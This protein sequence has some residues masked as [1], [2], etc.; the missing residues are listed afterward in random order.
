MNL[1]EYIQSLVN[2]GMSKEDMIP[3][4]EAFKNKQSSESGG[5]NDS[6]Q[7]GVTVDQEINAAP[8]VVQPD[9]AS[10]LE[11]TF[12]GLQKPGQEV[13]TE[14]D[15][16]G[17]VDPIVEKNKQ[18]IKDFS[19]RVEVDNP[20]LTKKINGYRNGFSQRAKEIAE[21][22]RRK[23]KDTGFEFTGTPENGVVVIGESGEEI[24]V[25]D[26][27]NGSFDLSKINDFISKNQDTNKRLQS[28][29]SNQKVKNYILD[30][31]K[32]P[33]EEGE[34]AFETSG[35]FGGKRGFGIFSPN[36]FDK[37]GTDGTLTD[38]ENKLPNGLEDVRKLL[39]NRYNETLFFSG[40][41]NESGSLN[42]FTLLT[43]GDATER[44]G[45]TDYKF[46]QMFN[47]AVDQIKG[48]EAQT[49]YNSRVDEL[50][51]ELKDNYNLSD[52]D[53]IDLT[54]PQT[55]RDYRD[56][57]EYTAF[58]K[59]IF[60]KTVNGLRYDQKDI[61]KLKA[62]II[63]K[64]NQVS[65]LL[66]L[67]E[68][69]E[70]ESKIKSLQSEIKSL[71]AK[72]VDL[73]E[74][75][76][77]E[78]T[79]LYLD[80][81]QGGVRFSPVETKGSVN[82]TQIKKKYDDEFRD[83]KLSGDFQD[84]QERF[85]FWGLEQIDL[86]EELDRK[87]S[88][89]AN[90]K[91]DF[92]EWFNM[93]RRSQ[94]SRVSELENI[95]Y[96]KETGELSGLTYRDLVSFGSVPGIDELSI[97]RDPDLK[98]EIITDLKGYLPRLKERL[99]DIKV[100]GQAL[101]DWYVMNIDPADMRRQG[102]GK[103]PR[104]KKGVPNVGL[105]TFLGSVGEG[106]VETITEDPNTIYTK[107]DEL[108]AIQ[109]VS[110]SIPGFQWNK[111]QQNN[112]KETNAEF[113]G[114]TLGAIA[115]IAVEFAALNIVSGGVATATGLSESLMAMRLGRVF[116]SGKQVNIGLAQRAATQAGYSKNAKAFKEFLGSKANRYRNGKKIY[117]LEGATV[118]EKGQALFVTGLIEEGKMQF[119]GLPTGSGFAFGTF[120]GLANSVTTRLG[121]SFSEASGFSALNG[122]LKLTRGGVTFGMA[123]EVAVNFEAAIEDAVG[124]KDFQSFIDEHYR[125]LGSD[126]ITRRTLG[127]VLTGFGFSMTHL[128][129]ADFAIRLKD[130]RNLLKKSYD[131][132]E[133]EIEKGNEKQAN[134]YQSL[135]G[136]LTR[137]IE[138]AEG[139]YKYY[140]PQILKNRVKKQIEIEAK[141]AK[142]DYGTFY[143]VITQ[144]GDGSNGKGIKITGAAQV[145]KIN[146]KETLVVNALN[147][148][149]KGL[150][151]HEIAHFYTDKANFTEE[152][153]E[154]LYNKIEKHVD[155]ATKDYYTEKGYKNFRNFIEGEYK[156]AGQTKALGAEKIT[157]LIEFMV[158]K[159]IIKAMLKNN[160]FRGLDK[161]VKDYYKTKLQKVGLFKN[162]EIKIEDAQD[163][164]N[165]LF[166]IANTKGSK[167][168]KRSWESLRNLVQF[169]P[170][171]EIIDV[172]TQKSIG[173]SK[174]P[175]S[176][177]LTLEGQ[178]KLKE[179]EQVFQ[180]ADRLI[181]EAIKSGK[182]ESNKKEIAFDLAYSYEN[183]IIRK[184]NSLKARGK[185]K[186]FTEADIK[187]VALEYITAEKQ[188]LRSKIEAFNPSKMINPNTGKPS[189]ATYL[190][191]S[192]PQGKLIDVALRKFIQENPNY[193]N[194][195]KFTSEEG[196]QSKVDKIMDIAT[197]TGDIS[198]EGVALS[199]RQRKGFGPLDFKGYNSREIIENIS[200]NLQKYLGDPSVLNIAETKG[201]A[202]KQ[203]AEFFNISAKKLN[204]FYEGKTK[205]ISDFS[206]SNKIAIEGPKGK[207]VITEKEAEKRG[208]KGF[209]EAS[210]VN[211]IQTTLSRNIRDFL[212]SI[213]EKNL[214]PETGKDLVDVSKE[215]VGG[216]LGIKGTTLKQA[217]EL[218]GKRPK[219]AAELALK[220]E[221]NPRKNEKQ[222]IENWQKLFGIVKGD[223]NVYSKAEHSNNLKWAVRL[224]EKTASAQ[225]LVK[226]LEPVKKQFTQEIADLTAGTSL[227]KSSLDLTRSQKLKIQES[228]DNNNF[229]FKN[230]FNE[231]EF[232]TLDEKSKQTILK[233]LEKSFNPENL[234][235]INN[236]DI[237]EVAKKEGVTVSEAAKTYLTN[238]KNWKDAQNSLIKLHKLKL[239]YISSKKRLQDP[240]YY[241]E[242]YKPFVGKYIKNFM[243]PGMPSGLAN[244][245][246]SQAGKGKLKV[247]N[248]TTGKVDLI[249][250][251]N[252]GFT[253]GKSF[254]KMTNEKQI[255]FIEKVY[256]VNISKNNKNN[257]AKISENYYQPSYTQSTKVKIE[258]LQKQLE[259]RKINEIELADK[260]RDIVS[261]G[262]NY[263]NLLKS[264]NEALVEHYKFFYDA[265]SSAKTK[266]AKKQA[267]ELV[268]G[269]LAESTN[270]ADGPLKGAQ[271]IKMVSTKSE[272]SP[273]QLEKIS[274]G[275]GSGEIIRLH[276][277]HMNEF[278]QTNSIDFQQILT[279]KNKS[280]AYEK[281]TNMVNNLG[282]AVTT[283]AEQYNKDFMG[284]KRG[285]TA[286]GGGSRE[287]L[288]P[289]VNTM[290]SKGQKESTIMLTEA[291]K[292]KTALEYLQKTYSSKIIEQAIKNI[293]ENNLNSSGVKIKQ[294]IDNKA[295]YK[296]LDANNRSILKKAGVK[297]SLDLTKS[298]L[299][300]EIEKIDKAN[301]EKQKAIYDSKDLNKDFNNIIQDRTGVEAFKTF[302]TAKASI[303]G[304][305]KGNWD[306]YVRPA[307]ED[308][309]GLIYKTLPKGKKGNAAMKWYQEN[310]IDPFTRGD[311]ATANERMSVLNDYKALVKQ[312]K[313]IPKTLKKE[314]AEGFTNE[315]AVRVYNWSKQDVK[316]PGISA[317]DAIKLT[318]AVENNAELKA[319]A[320]QIVEL[321]KGDG[322]PKPGENW[323]TGTI[324]TDLMAGIGKV[325]RKKHM[326][327]F[328]NNVDAIYTPENLNKLESQFGRSYRD[329]LENMLYR[330][331]TG[332]NR[333]KSLGKIES[334]ALEWINGSV[335][336]TMFFN[337]RSAAL[338][339]LSIPNYINLKDNN[340]FKAGAKFANQKQFWGDFMTLMNSNWAVSRR[341]GIKLNVTES[342]IAEAAARSGNKA[343]GAINYML[344][345]GFIFTKFADGFATA[346]GGSTMYRNRIETY[347]K[348]G[349][350]EKEAKEKA[351][352]DW[353]EIS[354]TT[355]QS[356][357]TDKISQEQASLGG[358]LVL[359]FGNTGMQ[360]TRIP[361]RA[362]QD[363]YNRRISPGYKT[364]FES[365]ASNVSKAVYYST[366]A[367]AVFVGLQNALF[368][369]AFNPD[370]DI[371]DKKIRAAENMVDN[372][373]R[374]TGMYGAAL[375]T[376]RSV[377]SK[378]YKESQDKRPEYVEAAWETLNVS[379]PIDIKVSKFKS[380]F[381]SLQYDMDDIKEKGALNPT[382]PAYLASAQVISGI[383]NLPLDRL[384]RKVNNLNSALQKN[385][386]TWQRIALIGGY[387]DYELGIEENKKKK[388][389]R[390][391]TF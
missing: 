287:A 103:G 65:D 235:M 291:F 353:E 187:Q 6:Q 31:L 347:K 172:K 343:Q 123:S 11:P 306:F 56:I 160:G 275:E 381:R 61:G 80:Y 98:E 244:S 294:Q 369:A 314:A 26:I 280:K 67:P 259:L 29:E 113:Y 390:K 239:D 220:P 158:E 70:N 48:K 54:D 128:K 382:N 247:Y 205:Q 88:I 325:K 9:M 99:I 210:E 68:S 276:F 162:H 52:K 86:D 328:I 298:E 297:S 35:V 333:P 290:L 212:Y 366:I 227:G 59:A 357:R 176:L 95:K 97:Y 236:I 169:E 89:Q 224:V 82:V 116:K 166:R 108:D 345:K 274:K 142:K 154:N 250:N 18:K 293:G 78:G 186:N 58:S 346:F 242:V 125:D 326:E 228:L 188:G 231:K 335:G 173:K 170:L 92:I 84:L 63:G 171:G 301:L 368:E 180:R 218:T 365:D 329:A 372:A 22:Y 179:T 289:I 45:T 378:L 2:Q 24:S 241:P 62:N 15:A 288:N 102:E 5:A 106:L 75:Y 364:Q 76:M 330:M 152:N 77:G 25:G 362:V 135:I 148:N 216:A 21:I 355:Q 279:V 27:R 132:Y 269:F 213:P 118:I 230:L 209:R 233:V 319:F 249:T 339:L 138:T 386:D 226:V 38:I 349:F 195:I 327:Q 163:I 383:T 295:N 309:T 376:M 316:I 13:S 207:E 256:G 248:S 321:N 23:Y 286:T 10:P 121:L 284:E 122:A 43:Q 255:E 311:K 44:D 139:H 273:K 361:K 47:E 334:A 380:A 105:A 112:F 243:Y 90:N 268:N 181:N 66:K 8:E 50:K 133:K 238:Q 73:V 266:A 91:G 167:G 222:A 85:N 337:T 7:T 46:D 183:E 208:V 57:P 371:D 156:A 40:E 42:P 198:K 74:D 318:K 282:Q 150:I 39:R 202:I 258:N 153:F 305:K 182:W 197:K 331:K 161:S 12:L 137:Q 223:L 344:E 246:L 375:S 143:D 342:E 281:I 221:Y 285:S 30:A 199:N 96:N 41:S 360:Y 252:Y 14:E 194:I 308:F 190:N 264:N 277:E 110:Q 175:S 34:T 191:S 115:P 87:I 262:K 254:S 120:G 192:T 356:G 134:K 263:E 312:I 322:Y 36:E 145:K 201:L 245:I 214:V 100:E 55:N 3:L 32:N 351:M 109:K 189:V 211:N 271:T 336:V 270:I 126:E 174:E 307:A 229:N 149:K 203:T 159:P 136:E 296:K 338:Q 283:R 359:A 93:A 370:A 379:P 363:L 387:S 310:L 53:Y 71:Q 384:F 240:K 117:S 83:I 141:Q 315:Q 79:E 377:A 323:L 51:L 324:T 178:R 19:N 151:P 373:L 391:I 354:E 101:T 303:Q 317:K 20:V 81:S 388:G 37:L 302:S 367:S 253:K 225:A 389:K 313:N 267:I 257:V 49:L 140:T 146:G 147:W 196:I 215:L 60:E 352:K 124:G 206:Y 4:I 204:D 260:V 184:L 261:G 119:M 104:E 28:K 304:K 185:L 168:V 164:M 348:E 237:M 17:Y 1:Q 114:N 350:S 111:E 177:D 341:N 130:K 200:N 155:V 69:E 292:G 385:R 265:V 131:L 127:N 272:A 107:S 299:I 320:E 94:G 232:K 234:Q 332:S 157:N 358:R 193:G 278:I 16:P 217:Y 219:N 374:G 64:A 144:I 300:K 33:Y 129:R 251:E 340:P 72:A 165:A